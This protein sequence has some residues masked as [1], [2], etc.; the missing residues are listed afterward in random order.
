MVLFEAVF[1]AVPSVAAR[2]VD[3]LCAGGVDEGLAGGVGAL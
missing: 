2:A 1:K 3:A